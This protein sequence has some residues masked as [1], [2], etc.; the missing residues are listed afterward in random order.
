MGKQPAARPGLLFLIG[1]RCSGKSTIARLLADRLGWGWVDADAVLEQRQGV[2]I[3]EIF[4]REGEEGFREKEAVLLRDL[5]SL[6]HQILATGGGVIL[7]EDNRAL[8]RQ[9]GVVVYLLADVDTLWERM[10]TDPTTGQRRPA[11]TGGGREEVVE[12]LRLREPLYRGCADHIVETANRNPE[13]IADEL[14]H[15]FA[16]PTDVP[17]RMDGRPPG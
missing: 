9:S 8:L 14:L 10:Q 3:R 5:C 6:R 16:P 13:A 11:L 17:A 4:A 15:W 2:S 1:P 12:V 7:R